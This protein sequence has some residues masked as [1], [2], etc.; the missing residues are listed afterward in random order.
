MTRVAYLVSHPIQYQAPL[1]RRLAQEETLDL[2]VLFLSDF[3]TRKYADAGF[4]KVI[5]WDVDLLSGYNWKVLSAWGSDDRLGFWTPVTAGIE[6]ELCQGRYDILWL[7]G[8]GH[9]AHLRAW[10]AAKR[11][12]LKVLFRGESHGLTNNGSSFRQTAKRRLRSTLFRNI[13]GFLAIGS[14]NREYYLS[15]G[16]P[17]DRIFMM[18]YAVDNAAFR[19]ERR[20]PESDDLLRQHKLTTGR[21]IILFAAK[22]Q[23]LKRPW[24]IWNAYIRLSPNGVDEP[25][26]YLIF[27]GEGSERARLEAAVADRG[28][29]RSVRFVGF[30]NQTI[31]PAYY[32]IADVF[33]L[34][35]D[36]EQ[37][38]LALNEAMNAGVAV[39]V[40]DQ[41][42]AR[43]DLVEDGVNGYVFPVGDVEA[44][45]DRLRRIT[46]DPLLARSMGSKSLHKISSW[47][48]EADIRGFH[49]AISFCVSNRHSAP[50]R[51]TPRQ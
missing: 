1:L 37:W 31:L 30:Q 40:S 21:P 3:S 4:G 22:L 2:T 28:W 34:A 5:S 46:G 42:G 26:P 19:R 39:I 41:V 10:F 20:S 6:R 18:P 51:D 16:V 9:Q 47:N 32:A 11:A 44:L 49:E 50:T 33:V 14:A 15:H 13:D 48:F 12:G 7:H 24:D 27:V 23:P 36:R 38:G 45:A 35:S 17:P 43:F 25:A 8:Y 29:G